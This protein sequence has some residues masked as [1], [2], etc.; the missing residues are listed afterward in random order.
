MSFVLVKLPEE[1][2][3]G[4]A[5]LGQIYHLVHLVTTQVKSYVTLAKQARHHRAAKLDSQKRKRFGVAK[6]LC[7]LAT[8][9]DAEPNLLLMFRQP[10]ILQLSSARITTRT[11]SLVGLLTWPNS[12]AKQNMMSTLEA[13]V[14]NK[15][16]PILC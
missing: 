3:Q 13:K 16:L 6:H 1:V 15:V 14:S 12:A 7:T 4:F 5:S 10:I 8:S 2:Y 9:R 11:M